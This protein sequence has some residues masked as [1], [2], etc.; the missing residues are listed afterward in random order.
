MPNSPLS[1][2]A[3]LLLH[4]LWRL[5]DALSRKRN[6]YWAFTTHHLHSD[7][8]IENQRALFEHV[9]A[10][11]EIRKLI[12]FRGENV[13]FE[14]EGA[15]N[16]EL[17]RHGTLRALMKLA[18]CRVVLI[19]HSISMDYALRWGRK[20]FAVLKIAT[21]SR[22]VVNLWHG[23]PLKRLLFTTNEKVMRHTDRTPFRRTERK[24]YAGLIA[25]SD[26][27]SYAMAAMFYPLNYRQI[28]LTGLPRNDFLSLDE[29]KLPQYMQ[30]SLDH[31]RKIR[32]DRH[33]VLYAPTYRQTEVSNTAYYYQ[34]GDDEIKRLKAILRR[35]NAVLAYRPH[36]FRNSQNYFNLDQ[37]ID[38]DMI[39]D[40]SQEAVPELSAA[41]RECRLLITDYSSACIETMY[42]GKPAIC[43]AYDLEQYTAEQDGML[44]DLNLVFPGPIVR[45]FDDLLVTLEQKLSESSDELQP[46]LAR[47]R[48]FF[49]KH[50]DTRNSE[51]VCDRIRQAISQ[52]EC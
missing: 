25:S 32:G 13:E 28:W 49:F 2:F 24:H 52:F 42:L 4:P 5:Y 30:R 14:I 22:V 47:T 51:R 15:V 29:S 10:N 20:T 43:F 23:I 41:A 21:H 16:Y 44:Y 34:F 17:I 26:I 35:S 8:F 9:K 46:E 11:H 6:D 40:M 19:T 39:V 48:K 37:Y 7:R 12:F 1:P 38:G 18:R 33:L 27:D 31:I 50:C 45:T 36:Y 3:F